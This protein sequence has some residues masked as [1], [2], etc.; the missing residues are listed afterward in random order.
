MGMEE[1]TC[2][3]SEPV[4]KGLGKKKKKKTLVLTNVR[5]RVVVGG[6]YIPAGSVD[7]KNS[8]PSIPSIINKIKYGYGRTYLPTQRTRRK[9]VRK[10]KKKKNL[11]INHGQRHLKYTEA[12][13]AIENTEAGFAIENTEAGFAI[14]NTEA[15]SAIE[16]A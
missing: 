16:N 15:G 11:G 8:E 2:L 14:E 1:H 3:H 12:G 7:L 6:D 9:R 5:K 10:K 13:F 4:G